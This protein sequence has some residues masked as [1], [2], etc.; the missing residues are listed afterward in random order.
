M[1]TDTQHL[2][3]E[4]FLKQQAD[5]FKM[6]PNERV[7]HGIYNN[8][9]PSRKVP[10]L[11]VASLFVFAFLLFSI[12]SNKRVYI[13]AS[14][15][16]IQ[17]IDKNTNSEITAS[18]T[19][20]NTVDIA[21]NINK[22]EATNARLMQSHNVS[23]ASISQKPQ[24]K[25]AP[26][27]AFKQT[28][29]TI[30]NANGITENELS[31]NDDVKQNL[32]KTKQDNPSDIA[33]SN[34]DEAGIAALTSNGVEHSIAN[35]T[36][37]E[38]IEKVINDGF[39]VMNASAKSLN[40]ITLA[41]NTALDDKKFRE[42]D[43]LLNK[44]KQSIIEKF[45][46]NGSIT[47]HLAANKSFR[48]VNSKVIND[49]VLIDKA[50]LGLEFGATANYPVTENTSVTVGAQFN[51]NNYISQLSKN[52][53]NLNGITSYTL[54]NY[55]ADK[56]RFNNSSAEISLPFGVN[57]AIFNGNNTKIIAN[58]QAQPSILLGGSAH[59]FDETNKQVRQQ[60]DVLRKFNLHTAA[61]L[62]VQ[63]KTA[64]NVAVQFG[65][66]VRY[67]LFSNH[68]NSFNYRESLQSFGLKLGVV[69]RF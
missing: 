67:Q 39:F 13:A 63:V 24:Y 23:Q 4:A 65:P 68:K 52:W 47:Y 54:F 42:N 8:L 32:S 5:S 46:A 40:S 26:H 12:S 37:N 3:F 61:S 7:W 10:S 43:I 48:Q 31:S 59:V 38:T 29:A 27:A 53:E 45:L 21:N 15:N 6:K 64:K 19:K 60:N 57:Y 50:A 11:A 56:Q 69:K 18:E 55:K 25:A 62:L 33:I 44:P 2:E 41:E 17:T 51:Y 16:A 14:K 58:V 28:L 9:H 66:Q 36:A 1:K 49:N 20:E 34:V 35:V 22:I 30:D